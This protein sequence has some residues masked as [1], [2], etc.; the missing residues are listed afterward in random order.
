MMHQTTPPVIAIMT[1]FGAG[2]GDVGVMKGVIAGIAPEAHLIDLTHEIA[3]QHVQS[4][5]WILSSAYQYFPTMS[6]FLCVVDPGVGSARQAIALHAGNWFFVGPDNGLFSYVMAEQPVHMAVQLTNPAFQMPRVSSTFHGR[7]I[8]APAAAHLA[9]LGAQ[10]LPQFGS[11]LAPD[12]LVRLSA[13]QASR[14]GS[15]IHGQIIH[16]DNFG[17]LITNIPLGMVPDLYTMPLPRLTFLKGQQ[18]VDQRRRF[19]ADGEEDGRAF[20]YGDSSGYV[21]VAVRNGSAARTLGAGYGSPF[22]LHTDA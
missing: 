6:V 22:I 5:A 20:L 19:F 21:G 2:D 16:V 8:F 13:G 10:A 12:S 9:H 17:N 1:D 11:A 4:A 18:V 7:D 14:E 15:S 3:P